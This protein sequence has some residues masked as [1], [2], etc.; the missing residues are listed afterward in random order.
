EIDTS[1][2]IADDYL[3]L[4]K[5]YQAE[6]QDSLA[7]VNYIKGYELDITNNEVLGNIAKTYFTSRQYDKAA[8]YYGKLTQFPKAS[9]VDWFYLGYSNYF[10]YANLI[11]SKSQDTLEI[12]NTLLA[13]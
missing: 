5:A 4:G 9:F 7:I 1:R 11:N 12:K 8:D 2:I 3:Y 6:K 10:H 13:A